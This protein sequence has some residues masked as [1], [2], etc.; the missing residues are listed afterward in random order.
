MRFFKCIEENSKA[1]IFKPGVQRAK[2]RSPWIN[3]R[4]KKID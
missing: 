2:E 1:K 3:E 4:I